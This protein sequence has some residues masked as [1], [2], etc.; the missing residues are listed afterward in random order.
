MSEEYQQFL[1]F[2]K[3]QITT[4]VDELIAEARQRGC[5]TE[6]MFGIYRWRNGYDAEFLKQKGDERK[7]FPDIA[8]RWDAM[9]PD[10]MDENAQL[11]DEVK[12]NTIL[13][14][15]LTIAA[16]IIL[17]LLCEITSE[18]KFH[19]DIQ[20]IAVKN[21]LDHWPTDAETKRYTDSF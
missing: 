5:N 15:F 16:F 19:G 6:A 20:R 17:F 2:K 14:V 13:G 3:T 12:P 1:A 9:C 10:G 4:P 11:W 21:K 18:G 8:K 7:K